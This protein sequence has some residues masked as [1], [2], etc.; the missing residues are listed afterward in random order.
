MYRFSPSRGMGDSASDSGAFSTQCGGGLDALNPNCWY[1]IWPLSYFASP[2]AVSVTATAPAPTGSVLT[3]P[4]ASGEE[5][6][7]T[8]DALLNQQLKNQQAIDAAQVQSSAADI[9]GGALA[10]AG[11]TISNAASGV[12]SAVSSP[13]LWLG[14]G[15]GVFALVALSAGSPRRYGR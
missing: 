1:Q 15:L 3:T 8:V 4:P 12:V 10:N 9:V 5:A 13:I 2:P 14:L 7:Q 6:Q 11:D